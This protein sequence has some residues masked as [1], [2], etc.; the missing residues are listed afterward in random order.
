MYFIKG[1]VRAVPGWKKHGICIL[2]DL[3]LVL[4]MQYSPCVQYPVIGELI[5]GPTLSHE[6]YGRPWIPVEV[7]TNGLSRAVLEPYQKSGNTR[8]GRSLGHF[9]WQRAPECITT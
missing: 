8:A 6:V 1:K 2:L 5:P 7:L 4:T 9:A 3:Q